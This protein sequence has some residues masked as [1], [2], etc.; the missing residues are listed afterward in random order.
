MKCLRVLVFNFITHLVFSQET[1][2]LKVYHPSINIAEIMIIDGKYKDALENYQKAFSNV[3]R[4]FMK[5]YFNAAVCATYLDDTKSTYKYLLE[6]AGKGISLDFI[7]DEKAFKDI[8]LDS[9][10]RTFEK[11]YLTRK[12]D[13]DLKINKVLKERLT[14]LVERDKQFRRA[15]TESF[16]DSI[17]KIDNQNSKE[18]DNLIT[19]YGFPSEDMIGS[20]EGGMPVIQYPFLTVI[21]RQTSDKQTINF[22]NRLM[23]ATKSGKISPHATA[24]LMAIINREDVFWARYVFKIVPSDPLLF[25]DKPFSA[26]LNKW[27]FPEI[28][29]ID[30]Q[31]INDLRLQNGMETLADYRKKILF[32]LKDS[33]FLF[34][35]SVYAGLWSVNNPTMAANYLEGTIVLE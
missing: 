10:W 17:I 15:D 1:N 33:R 25:Q 7:K 14:H 29:A 11:Q 24:Y 6:V 2:Y 5:D 35:Y 8:Q 22:S 30:E 31:R 21:R 9:N 19:Q 23:N 18:L 13:F 4:G 32:S 27:I 28:K 26:K 3:Q 20:G 34:P 12:R 16:A